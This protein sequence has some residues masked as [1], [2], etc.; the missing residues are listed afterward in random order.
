MN[1]LFYTSSYSYAFL[2]FFPC[3]INTFKTYS[4]DMKE[5]IIGKLQ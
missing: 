5:E 3:K 2:V 1:K 4:N